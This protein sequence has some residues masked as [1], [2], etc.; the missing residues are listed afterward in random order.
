MTYPDL[1]GNFNQPGYLFHFIA[2]KTILTVGFSKLGKG[3]A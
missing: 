3:P 2:I 1:E